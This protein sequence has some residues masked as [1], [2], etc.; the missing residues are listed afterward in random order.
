MARK[1]QQEREQHRAQVQRAAE[2]DARAMLLAAGVI[3][4]KGNDEDAIAALLAEPAG[5]PSL[6][7]TVPE[8]CHMMRISQSTFYRSKKK[9]RAPPIVRVMGLP[10]IT[11]EAAA[12]WLQANLQPD[13]GQEALRRLDDQFRER[14]RA[15]ASRQRKPQVRR[16]RPPEDPDRKRGLWDAPPKKARGAP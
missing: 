15:K 13:E 9:G 11:A 10:R 12:Q 16:M 14:E 1:S 2:A 8:F 6:L 3:P 5:P 7:Y 4:G